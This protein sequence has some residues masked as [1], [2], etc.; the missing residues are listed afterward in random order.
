L[1]RSRRGPA[2]K[3]CC[4]APDGSFRR[5]KRPV[6]AKAPYPVLGVRGARS[7]GET[8]RPKAERQES[9]EGAMKKTLVVDNHPL[10]LKF[11]ANLLEKEGHRVF[12]AE[13]GLAALDVLKTE[14][15]D[16]AFVDLVMPN[17]GGEKLCSIIRRDPRTRG[18]FLVVLSAVAA[19][20]PGADMA[21][22]GADCCI[23]KGPLNKMREH[24]LDALALA[25]GRPSQA[26]FGK[27]AGLDDVHPREITRELLSVKRH[28]EVVLE[29]MNDGFLEISPDARIVYANPVAASLMGMGEEDLLGMP[30]KKVFDEKH[31]DRVMERL[32][33]LPAGPQSLE[34]EACVTV[35]GRQ[36][37]LKLLPLGQGEPHAVAILRDVTE[38]RRGELQLRQAQRMKSVGTLAAGV[39]HDFNNLLMGIQGNVSLMLLDLNPTHP[40]YERLRS[41]EGL[42]SSGSRL[43][44]QLLGYASKGRYQVRSLSL[45]HLVKET[46]ETFGRTRKEVTV[47]LA[48]AQDLA[49]IEAD[50]GQMEQVLL[51]LFFN[52]A[53]AMPQGG[54][55][56]LKTVNTHHEEMV[57]KIFGARPGDYV[58]LTVTDTGV[59]MDEETI[60]HI[61]DPFFT[62]GSMGRGTGLGLASVYGIVTGHGGYIHV[63]SEKGGGATF[64]I[65]LPAA[66][67]EDGPPE[68]EPESGH[69]TETIL[70]VE[71]EEVVRSVNRD[72]LLSMGFDVWAA[73]GG[74]EAVEIY[75]Q[76]GKNI[77]LVLLDIVMP[78]MGGRGV[79]EE[80][81]RLDPAV[82]VLLSSGY[83]V[84]GQAKEM[85]ERGCQG[86][87]QKPF[88]LNGLRRS[89]RAILDGS[90]GKGPQSPESTGGETQP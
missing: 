70:L 9:R 88:N 64:R 7:K 12:T 16:I 43:T 56:F 81:K 77:D 29:S 80:L 36:V 48:L 60:A 26:I 33:A 66:R 46:A 45:N 65:Y 20:R 61:F 25:Q 75:K 22:L 59:G 63:Q 41:V 2:S 38:K 87:I 74:R 72:M 76:H 58:L 3:S 68:K 31:R 51:N 79:Y 85:L 73:A 15:P 40:H 24:V 13:D 49:P 19:E 53:N 69:K 54:D 44:S 21:A 89:L 4:R 14:V 39:A 50:E 83:S 6:E 52:A 55:L 27:T 28:F 32:E 30:L 82:R 23:A 86:F 62:T 37:E 67:R 10:I 17:I 8:I 18:V 1:S 47:H 57:D 5:D 34:G 71:D 42:V 84:E 90:K 78:E 11:M 35:N